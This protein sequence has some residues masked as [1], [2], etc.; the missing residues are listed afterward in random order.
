MDA[1]DDF[2]KLLSDFEYASNVYQTLLNRDGM[3]T[4]HTNRCA[5]PRINARA[6]EKLDE[7]RQNVI[8]YVSCLMNDIEEAYPKG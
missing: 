5:C 2:K 1:M 6:K 4:R 8:A 3:A 7:A